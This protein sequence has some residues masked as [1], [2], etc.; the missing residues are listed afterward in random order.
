MPANLPPEYFEAEKHYKNASTT[1]EKITTLE[2]L[3]ATIPKHKG[4][5]KLRADLRRRLSKFKDEAIQQKKKKGSRFDIYNVEREGSAQAVLVGLANS[6][7][8]S[9]LASLTNAEPVIA[10]YP[11]STITPLPGMMPFEDIQVQL[12][13]LP[14]IGNESTDGWVSSIIRQTDGIILLADLTEDPEDSAELLLETLKS[15]NI[16]IIRSGQEPMEKSISRRGIIAGTKYDL[17]GAETGF[18]KLLERFSKICP[19]IPFSPER[20]DTQETFKSVI[21]DLMEIIRVYSKEPGKKPDME[22]PFTLTRGSTVLDLCK[23]IHKEFLTNLKYAKVWGSAKF[24]G[25][26][27]QRDYV[28]QDKDIVEIHI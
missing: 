20:T 1:A 14:P 10:V 5:D 8:S 4:T 2:E 23:D 17:P 28:L 21:F 11:M 15:W 25:Q 13:D 7:K 19:V 22:K 3:I 12:V 26:K 24:D 16:H 6:G 27:V 18:Y 9:L